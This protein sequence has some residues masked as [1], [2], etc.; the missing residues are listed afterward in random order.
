MRG[1]LIILAFHSVDYLAGRFLEITVTATSATNAT[2]ASSGIGNSGVVEVV[3]VE[4]ESAMTETVLSPI[5]PANT[6]LLVES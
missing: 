5:L 4:V 6:S 1:F 2:T 3:V